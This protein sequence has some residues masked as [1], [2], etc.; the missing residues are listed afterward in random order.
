MNFLN[1][2]KKAEKDAAVVTV[3]AK[4]VQNGMSDQERRLTKV[5][6][7]YVALKKIH[8]LERNMEMRRIDGKVV[9]VPDISFAHK[10]EGK[11]LRRYFVLIPEGVIHAYTHLRNKVGRENDYSLTSRGLVKFVRRELLDLAK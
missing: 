8:H 4:I 1:S 11:Q 2:L 10:P 9:Y 6:N 5:V 3:A 7:R